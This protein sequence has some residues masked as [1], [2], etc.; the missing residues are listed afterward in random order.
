MVMSS[1]LH[2]WVPYNAESRNQLITD[3]F[4]GESGNGSKQDLGGDLASYPG[5]LTMVFSAARGEARRFLKAAIAVA[6]PRPN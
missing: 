2:Q 6:T 4:S 3:R 5:E 1:G